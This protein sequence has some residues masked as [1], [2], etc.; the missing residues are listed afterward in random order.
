ME[1]S[2]RRN[3]ESWSSVAVAFLNT[4]LRTVTMPCCDF[5]REGM[6]SITFEMQSTAWSRGLGPGDSSA[7]ADDAISELQAASNQ[8]HG[9]D[10]GV[11]AAG[12]QSF[13]D[14]RSAAASSGW[15]RWGSNDRCISQSRGGHLAIQISVQMRLNLP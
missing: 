4:V 2:H 6:S 15:N 9:D 8:P 3:R 5:E 14:A 7:Q 11:P 10:G 12:R 13:K 1:S